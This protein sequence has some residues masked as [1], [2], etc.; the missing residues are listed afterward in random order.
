MKIINGF[1]ML[2]SLLLNIILVI[3]FLLMGLSASSCSPAQKNDPLAIVQEAYDRLNEGD[4]DGYMEFISEDAVYADLNTRLV[5]AQAIREDTQISAG[6]GLSRF[7]ISDLMMDNNVVYFTKDIYHRDT[8]VAKDMGAVVVVDGLI[9]FDG[10]ATQYSI[11]CYHD[12]SQK[13][14]PQK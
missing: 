10:S 6:P 12:P 4:I 1:I 5:G 13:F 11:E 3:A 2:P 8:W 7:V 9:I 14:C